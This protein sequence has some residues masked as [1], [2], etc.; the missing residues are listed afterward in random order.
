MHTGEVVE[1]LPNPYPARQHRDIGNEARI[2]H[3]LIALGPGI[4]S[5]HLQFSLIGGEAENRIERGSLA[6]AVGTDESENAA[7]LHT[8]IDA[9][10]RDRCSERL[11]ETTC[12]YA[13]HGFS[14]PLCGASTRRFSTVRHLMTTCVL[15][16]HLVLPVSGRAAEWLRGPGAI[17][18]QET[19]AVRPAATDCVRPY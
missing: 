18:R 2:A 10:H 7:L 11:P 3:K 6:C 14:A 12:F 17:L 8:Q 13:G 1:S 19:S 16:Q 15:R 9:V 4:A 5:E